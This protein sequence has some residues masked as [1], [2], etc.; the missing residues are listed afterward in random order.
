M[1]RTGEG[2]GVG[3]RLRHGPAMD[4]GA[5]AHDDE[6]QQHGDEKDEQQQRHRLPS[7]TFDAGG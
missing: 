2:S 1:P 5:H 4:D 3:R 7:S 6:Q